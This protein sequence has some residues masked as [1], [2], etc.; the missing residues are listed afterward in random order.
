M[1]LETIFYVKLLCKILCNIICDFDYYT[2]SEQI[3]GNIISADLEDWT[4]DIRPA[5][6]STD[7]VAIQYTDMLGHR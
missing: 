1:V 6:F 2:V 7:R 3:A 5:I 4:W